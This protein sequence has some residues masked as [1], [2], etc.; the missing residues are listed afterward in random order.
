MAKLRTFLPTL[1]AVL[2]GDALAQLIGSGSL[3]STSSTVLRVISAMVGSADSNLASLPSDG[4]L[5]C[6]PSLASAHCFQLAKSVRLIS[7]GDGSSSLLDGLAPII[8][9]GGCVGLF[10]LIRLVWASA[11]A[12]ACQ[13]AACVSRCSIPCRAMRDRSCV[14]GRSANDQKQKLPTALATVSG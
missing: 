7:F 12:I 8:P 3:P 1:V 2:D 14:N 5:D 13:L 10:V 4:G 6:N 9:V 11:E